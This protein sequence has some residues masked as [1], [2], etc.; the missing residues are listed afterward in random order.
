MKKTIRIFLLALVV[1]L[2]NA[3]IGYHQKTKQG[4]HNFYLVKFINIDD[5]AYIY[6]PKTDTILGT[7]NISFHGTINKLT[8]T[9]YGDVR[10]EGYELEGTLFSQELGGIEVILR[11]DKNYGEIHFLSQIKVVEVNQV[12]SAIRCILPISWMMK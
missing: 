5:S 4:I 2:I 7:K 10:V 12:L 9:F 3:A 1:F 11:A 8:R 6:D